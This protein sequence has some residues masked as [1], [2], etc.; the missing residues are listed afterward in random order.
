MRLLPA[1]LCG[2]FAATL[3]AQQPNGVLRLVPDDAFFVAWSGTPGSLADHFA[4]TGLARLAASSE[5]TDALDYASMVAGTALDDILAGVDLDGESLGDILRD[6]KGTFV[7]AAGGDLHAHPEGSREQG[8]TAAVEPWVVLAW[9]PQNDTDLQHLSEQLS[10]AADQHLGDQLSELT[11]SGSHFR[12][13][14][15]DNLG[16]FP[17]LQTVMPFVENSTLLMV[18][19][20]DPERVLEKVLWSPEDT[21]GTRPDLLDAPVGIW[22]N[23]AAYQTAVDDWFARMGPEYAG[24]FAAFLDAMGLRAIKDASIDLWPAEEFVA[25]EFRLD[26]RP[27][28][29]GILAAFANVHNH[30]LRALDFVPA[31][32]DNWS[33]SRCEIVEVYEALARAADALGLPG[34][35]REDLEAEFTEQFRVQLRQDL[36]DHMG[37][38]IVTVGSPKTPDED[39]LDDLSDPMA[40]LDGTCFG[41]TLRD[42]RSFD[43]SFEAVLRSR[44]LHAARKTEEY[45]SFDVHRINVL[46]TPVLYT[47]SNE[48]LL[49]A[50]GPAGGI[51][52]REVLD[53]EH[54][55]TQGI[56]RQPLPEEILR[57]LEQAP[58][59][60]TGISVASLSKTVQDMAV[61]LRPLLEQSGTY[62]A[63]D[64]TERILTTLQEL[65]RRHDLDQMVGVSFVEG[66]ALVSRLIW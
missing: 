61:S 12:V 60:I 3:T 2:L 66:S 30:P 56:E 57:R 59:S 15:V 18:A 16:E 46:G 29:R 55:R 8:W 58:E 4:G 42:P 17:D 27:D 49:V 13:L 14:G 43:A 5:V 33:I 32:Q 36:I 47:V 38:E 39:E 41:I 7:L 62:E 25:I 63:A 20:T 40:G 1:T 35:T 44:G 19:G 21:L 34:Y 45:R 24:M 51:A 53:E 11:L 48:L 31:H 50:V 10:L 52:L 23:I 6:D 65:V 22:F 9:E 54:D 28:D 26:M 37:D 64:T